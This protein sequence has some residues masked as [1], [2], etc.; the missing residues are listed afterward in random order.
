MSMEE[1]ITE[2]ETISEKELLALQVLPEY[3][4]DMRNYIMGV[5]HQSNTPTLTMY[6]VIHNTLGT[7]IGYLIW[8]NVGIFVHYIKN[9]Y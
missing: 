3:S 6:A 7:I 1:K 4:W 9:K 8:R 2:E 5:L